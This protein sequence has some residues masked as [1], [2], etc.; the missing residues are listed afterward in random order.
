MRVAILAHEGASPETNLKA[1][2]GVAS[3]GRGANRTAGRSGPRPPGLMAWRGQSLAAPG[4]LPGAGFAGPHPK[5]PRWS[6]ESY[7]GRP[8]MGGRA[9]QARPKLRVRL[10]A[11]HPPLIGETELPLS[12]RSLV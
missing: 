4:P 2:R 1:E 3:R 12:Q 10:S 6:A 8:G 5:S 9:S 11:L 7:P